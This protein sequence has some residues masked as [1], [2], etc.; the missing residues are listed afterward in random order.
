ML[1]PSYSLLG[2]I[3]TP[4]NSVNALAFSKDGRYLASCGDDKMVRV[5]DVK[6]SLSA[7]WTYQGK[8]PFTT[9]IWN[10]EYL[11]TGNGDGEVMMFHPRAS[12]FRK[13]RDK[14]IA[15][16]FTPIYF[17]ELNRIGNQLLVCSG[18]R[19]TLLMERKSGQWKS[20]SH[21]DSPS[22]FEESPDFGEPDGFDEPQVLAISAHF[23]NEKD[24]IVIGYLHHGLWKYQIEANAGVLVWGPD[25]KIGSTVLSPDGAALAVTNIRSGVDWLKVSSSAGVKWKKMSTSTEAQ[26][27]TSN[28]PLPILFIDKG[29]HI[30]MATSKGY[31][32][33]FHTKHGKK[34]MSLDH[35]ND[36]TWITA[37]AYVHPP[38]MPQLI[39]TGNGNC[40]VDTKIKVWVED[41]EGKEAE[42]VMKTSSFSLT[43]LCFAFLSIARIG[44]CIIG[45]AFVILLLLRAT[46]LEDIQNSILTLLPPRFPIPLQPYPLPSGY[47][48][49][50]LAN[51]MLSSGSLPFPESETIT[52]LPSPLTTISD[53][54]VALAPD[55]V[56]I[57]L[58]TPST[59]LQPSRAQSH[60]VWDRIFGL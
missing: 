22:S 58:D 55:M 52:S 21:F 7:I 20:R 3:E 30:I 24:C 18:S 56:L 8:S 2:T 36:R 17:L 50:T 35:G 41:T 46:G 11:F 28:I 57:T 29:K 9:V 10:K 14:L 33:I 43:S 51:T 39:A 1:D 4:T 19:T 60:G 31:A 48:A 34:I 15:E 59:T 16:F 6:H 42:S 5:Y 26:D 45:M 40:G 27:S 32:A 12:W 54:I 23:L 25:E 53:A 47:S 49:P 38:N 37:L 13:Q 44:F